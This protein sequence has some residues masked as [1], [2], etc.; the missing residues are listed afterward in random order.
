MAKK[1]KGREGY[2]LTPNKSKPRPIPHFLAF[3]CETNGTD[4][5]DHE[6]KTAPGE[7]KC[8]CVYGEYK[9]YD[10]V[11]KVDL[12][13]T[14]RE[15]LTNFFKG[16]TNSKGNGVI[17]Q[18]VGYNLAF[19]MW[20]VFDGIDYD[21]MIMVGSRIIRAEL[22]NGIMMF[23]LWNH[24]GQV[25]LEEWF[26]KLNL[27]EKGLVK[28]DHPELMK[29]PELI[30]HCKADTQATWEVAEYFKRMYND[31]G[32]SF[33]LTTSAVAMNLFIRKF[34]W[35]TWG[36]PDEKYKNG[37][38]LNEME[39]LAYYGGRVE[40]FSRGV[41][42]V[43]SYDVNSMYV[44][45]MRDGLLPVPNQSYCEYRTHG[46]EH[47]FHGKGI[48]PNLM[49][50]HCRVKA[51]KSRVMVLPYR[52]PVNDKLIF[53]WGEFSGWWTSPELKV[54]LEYGYTIEKVYEYILY[55]KPMKFL[56]QYAEFCYS[57][58]MIAKEAGDEGLSTIWKLMGNGLYG[59]FGQRNDVSS[60]FAAT[61]PLGQEGQNIMP[62]SAY[63]K[64]M[65]VI[66][67]IEKK[68][69]GTSFPCVSAFIT[70]YAR[71]KILKYL[72]AH[73]D[74][75]CYCDTDSVK[76][77]DFDLDSDP[78]SERHG[79]SKELGDMKFEPE[80]SGL[81]LFLKPKLYGSVPTEGLNVFDDYDWLTP[82]DIHLTIPG[83]GWKIKGLGTKCADLEIDLNKMSLTGTTR[84]PS[85]LKDSL[86]RRKLP[87]VW[88]DMEKKMSII[89]DKRVWTKGSVNSEPLHVFE[90]PL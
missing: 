23:D 15:D 49:I 34:H 37:L 65:F 40:V 8:A 90:E 38:S 24:G 25:A 59:K 41:H 66:S 5:Y 20:Y 84:R 72:K 82:M 14:N 52:D 76:Y 21:S 43:Q 63:G 56:A 18:I 62:V 50:V 67:G 47:Y 48:K 26:E 35:A 7:M 51:P 39:R 45:A 81:Y 55:R 74:D 4:E 71:L 77:P 57:N 86:R 9:L 78:K 75:V 1:G 85:K 2:W 44:S 58:R 33:K 11:Y 53:P 60:G 73:E 46:F 12:T 19:D 22:G 3:D 80:H 13:F 30:E 27:K 70:S 10:K 89:D 87:N 79:T 29:L 28:T 64:D 83:N 16:L 31:M 17:T 32:V 69:S 54:A 6:T 42:N 68:D 61:A 36:R 88:T